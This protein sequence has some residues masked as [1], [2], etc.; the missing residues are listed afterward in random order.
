MIKILV[1]DPLAEAGLQKFQEMD[2]VEAE[3]KTGLG[4][5]ELAAIVGEYDGMIVRSGVKVTAKVL[6]NPGKLKVVARAG[7]GVDNIDLDAATQS[8]ILVMNT[9]DANTISTAEQTMSLILAMSRHVPNA[10]A[11]VRAK[12]WN[13]KAFM[14]TQLA[15]KTLGIIGLGRVGQAVAQRAAGFDMKIIAYD[16]FFSGETAMDGL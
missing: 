3:V 1:A 15:G 6:E 16:P 5:D 9:P 4:E 7:V 13:R 8:G 11:H 10:D 12:E 2:G 14:G